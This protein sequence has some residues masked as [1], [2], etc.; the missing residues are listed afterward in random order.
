MNNSISTL[1]TEPKDN[2][3]VKISGRKD[4]KKTVS[5]DSENDITIVTKV[6]EFLTGSDPSDAT[7][8]SLVR[9]MWNPG[10]NSS[11]CWIQGQIAKRVDPYKGVSKFKWETNRV[12]VRNLE[13]I[14]C[15]GEEYI[16]KLPKT[17]TVDLSRKGI[18]ALGTEVT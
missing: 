15:W 2:K 5:N 18:W 10:N 17:M 14:N 1:K 12:T 7:I 16:R 6:L 11:I 13:I 9:F 8:G 4:D 3:A